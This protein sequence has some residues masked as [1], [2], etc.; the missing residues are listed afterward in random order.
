MEPRA[1]PRTSPGWVTRPAPGAATLP[2]DH[3]PF[4][5]NHGPPARMTVMTS[6]GAPRSAPAV[7]GGDHSGRED[8]DRG[9]V[10]VV[11]ISS[12]PVSAAQGWTRVPA[13]RIDAELRRGCGARRRPQP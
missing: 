5:P 6:T 1:S 11:R 4:A 12:P 13:V 3:K 8:D 10:P 2:G 9:L 7:R